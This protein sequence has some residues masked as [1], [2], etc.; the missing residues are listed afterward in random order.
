[1][2]KGAEVIDSVLF[3]NNIVRA[4]SRITRTV[5]DVNT[6]FGAECRIGGP[7]GDDSREGIT[8]IGWNNH[9]PEKIRIGR[10]CT[11]F[12]RIADDGW[13]DTALPDNEVLR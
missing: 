6:L 8:V 13:P 11:V 3:F 5:S 12:P 4:G 7:R 10:G 1:V 9:V 2:E